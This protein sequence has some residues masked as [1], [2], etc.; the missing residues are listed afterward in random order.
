MTTGLVIASYKYGHL[1]A[2]AIESALDQTMR[3]DHIWFVDDGIGDCTHLPEIYPEVEYVLRRERLGTVKNFQDMLMNHVTTE[4]VMFLGADNWLRGD[5][6]QQLNEYGTDIVMYDIMVV[7]DRKDEIHHRHP[8]ET[9]PKEGGLYWHRDGKHHGSML[10]NVKK[11]KAVGG[12]ESPTQGRTLE[13]MALFHKLLH[14]GA[15]LHHI[16]DTFLYYR[17]HRENFNKC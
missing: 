15:T 14:S 2:Q 1:A 5:T 4:R 7:G 6:V 9:F 10:Y 16:K 3:F 11:A 13:D 17:R 12:Y 8:G